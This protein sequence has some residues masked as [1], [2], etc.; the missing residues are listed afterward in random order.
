MTS[1][2]TPV[3]LSNSVYSDPSSKP[4]E[5][6]QKVVP[7]KFDKNDSNGKMVSKKV[8]LPPLGA[9]AWVLTFEKKEDA[10]PENQ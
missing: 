4:K 6:P 1:S 9:E 10:E 7:V 2:A 8:F 5:K 3:D